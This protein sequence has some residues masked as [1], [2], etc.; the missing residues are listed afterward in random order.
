MMTIK[1]QLNHNNKIR[2][3]KYRP[4]FLI[5]RESTYMYDFNS[6]ALWRTITE[7]R[8]KGISDPPL[9]HCIMNTVASNDCANAILAVG[10]KPVMA[11]SPLESAEI[12]VKSKAV[13]LNMGTYSADKELAMLK[14][15]K[16]ANGNFIP[17][18]LDPVGVH[19][20][21]FR[22]KSLSKLL[23]KIRFFVI[24]GNLHEMIEVSGEEVCRSGKTGKDFS[25]LIVKTAAQKTGAV[26]VLTG[27]TDF[28]SD[29]K[30]T[31]CIK[32]GTPRLTAITATGCMTGALIGAFSTISPNLTAALSGVSLMNLC[33]EI[34][35][36]RKWG[37]GSMKVELMDLLSQITENDIKSRL[38]FFEFEGD[39]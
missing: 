16:S 34:A 37:T 17:V 39:K 36:E 1:K 7:L 33:G 9:V 38:R 5:R 23:E 19:A 24:K 18:I 13:V 35:A 15:G 6:D 31:Y 4:A 29:G 25:S 30:K 26:C 14:S 20:T 28:I 11:D 2:A 8:K 12:S 10:G 22:K 21:T 32:N 27:E 3:E